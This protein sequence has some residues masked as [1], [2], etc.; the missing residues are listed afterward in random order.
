MLHF[1]ILV[2][3]KENMFGVNS[4]EEN[5]CC[6]EIVTKLVQVIDELIRKDKN[7][8]LRGLR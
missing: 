7:R 6:Q 1:A 2:K 3:E 5:D 8:D 4:S